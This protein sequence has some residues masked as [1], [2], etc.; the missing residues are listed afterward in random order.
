M[1]N[2]NNATIV[3]NMYDAFSRADIGYILG[4][5]ADDCQWIGAGEG[6]LPQGGTYKG[7]EAVNFFMNL[8]ASADFTSFNPTSINSINENEVVAFGNM[9]TVSKATGKSSSSDWAMH[10]KFNAEGKVVYYH[11]FH[12]TAAEYAANQP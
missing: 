1:S 7:K 8:A 10:W 3:A 6:F 9:S 5:I 12:D 11:D 2:A 4:Y